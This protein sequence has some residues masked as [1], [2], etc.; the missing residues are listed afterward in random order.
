MLSYL[1]RGLDVILY[2]F[3]RD[4]SGFFVENRFAVAGAGDGSI[5]DLGRPVSRLLQLS[6]F[7]MTGPVCQVGSGDECWR[8]AA[9]R[10]TWFTG[11]EL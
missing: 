8:E 7:I 6:R 4:H 1:E 2:V 9:H 3:L 11:W 5:T 10:T